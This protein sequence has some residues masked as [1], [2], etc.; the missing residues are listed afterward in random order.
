MEKLEKYVRGGGHAIVTSGFV[1]LMLGRGCPEN[2]PNAAGEQDGGK[3]VG[4]GIEQ[5]TSLR[6]R[7]RH[8]TPTHYQ[9][10]S[11]DSGEEYKLPAHKAVSF[12]LLEHRNNTSWMLVK[13]QTEGK[14]LPILVRDCYG[15]GQMVTL[16]VPDDFGD[17]SELPREILNEIRR[18][19]C[20]TLGIRLECGKNVGL[21][22]YDDG[23]FVTYAYDY[24][25]EGPQPCYVHVSGGAKRLVR[26]NGRRGL[27]YVEP[28]ASP[29]AGA[30]EAGGLRGGTESVFKIE[31]HPDLFG[32]WKIER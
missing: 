21:F 30:R 22:L 27:E 11:P 23:S 17:L 9:Y 19:F 24:Q 29:D 4:R 12:P 3:T 10:H 13:G 5:M 1:R 18:E 2:I 8:L 16:A 25:N 15:L 6:Y 14:N 26:L 7:G 20:R 32:F 28:Y 31:T